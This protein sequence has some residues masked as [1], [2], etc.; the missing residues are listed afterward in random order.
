[1]VLTINRV[2]DWMVSAERRSMCIWKP[3]GIILITR[4]MFPVE[5]CVYMYGCMSIATTAQRRTH[6][7]LVHDLSVHIGST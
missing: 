7:R 1:M 4:W 3:P 2:C 5:I 6:C